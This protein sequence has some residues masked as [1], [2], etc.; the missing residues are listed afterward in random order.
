[1][2]YEPIDMTH[3]DI[4]K[5]FNT[6]AIAIDT[7]GSTFFGSM[8]DMIVNT[9]KQIVNTLVEAGRFNLVIWT[10]DNKVQHKSIIEF[11]D[12]NYVGFEDSLRESMKYGCGGS[13]YDESFHMIKAL[14]LKLDAFV[15]ITDGMV[16]RP[17][18]ELKDFI[19]SIKNHV[20]LLSDQHNKTTERVPFH[21]VIHP[22]F[23]SN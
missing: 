19:E 4:Q 21:A 7:S 6:V 1:M 22:L 3:F 2:T 18:P 12:T 23:F 16:M 13:S 8:Q 14:G 10:F 15:I 20:I 11:N 5:G 9:V 17:A